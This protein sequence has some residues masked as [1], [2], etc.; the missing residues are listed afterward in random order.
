MVGLFG[1]SFIT[2]TSFLYIKIL[3]SCNGELEEANENVNTKSNGMLS[4][5]FCKSKKHN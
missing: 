4:R 1:I 2:A 5:F 3:S